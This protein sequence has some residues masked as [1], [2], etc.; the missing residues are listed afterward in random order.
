[1][2]I[3]MV[4]VLAAIMNKM[5]GKKKI[6]EQDGFIEY[7]LRPAYY[8]TDKYIINYLYAQGISRET[9]I[10]N[11]ELIKAEQARLKVKRL[12]QTKNEKRKRFKK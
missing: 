5:E 4:F 11:P 2:I 12:I 6:L 10:N 1:M 3:Y 8:L 7:C 9:T